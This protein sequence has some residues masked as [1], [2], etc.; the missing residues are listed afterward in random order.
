M[1]WLSK[2]QSSTF[3]FSWW[4]S[5][6]TQYAYSHCFS[7][8]IYPTFM[9]WSILCLESTCFFTKSNSKSWV[10]LP[11]ASITLTVLLIQS[12]MSWS[13]LFAIFYS[14][15]VSSSSFNVSCS[16]YS[17]ISSTSFCLIFILNYSSAFISSSFNLSSSYS[18]LFATKMTAV[19]LISFWI[20]CSNLRFLSK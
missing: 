1:F 3:A 8:R 7:A 20:L 5:L 15:F 2:N 9:L 18:F 16:S 12:S 10:L 19:S 11:A 6:L 4:I 14:S 17:F 13:N